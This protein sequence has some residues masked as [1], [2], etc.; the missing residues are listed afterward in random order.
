MSEQT[1]K[2]DVEP[3]N[4]PEVEKP[5]NIAKPDVSSRLEKFRSKR[6]P[7]IEN[8]QTLLTALLLFGVQF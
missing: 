3:S 2:I 7:T 5:I 4:E 1:K 6:K 8:V